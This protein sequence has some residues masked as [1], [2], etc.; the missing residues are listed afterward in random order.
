M[1]SGDHI[2]LH[3]LGLT[4]HI[5]VSEEERATPQRLEADVTLWTARPLTG[6]NDDLARQTP[7]LPVSGPANDA[8]RE[9]QIP[10]KQKNESAAASD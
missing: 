10:F 6:L 2:T 4:A 1:T 9:K 3:G 5:G 8:A 7:S